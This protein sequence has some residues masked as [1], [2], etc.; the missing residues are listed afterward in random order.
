MEQRMMPLVISSSPTDMAGSERQLLLEQVETVSV[1][2]PYVNSLL[3]EVKVLVSESIAGSSA[4]GY[5]G[6]WK[7]WL[8]FA[9]EHDLVPI[10]AEPD[11][12]AAHFV[13][14][15]SITESLAPALSAR[16]A[17][18]FFH[19]MSRPDEV[20]PRDSVRVSMAMAGL[21][22]RYAKPPKK[23][24]KFTPSSLRKVVDYLMSGE[25]VKLKDH[26][27][28]VFASCLWHTVAR[29]EELAKVE[30]DQVRVLEGGSIEL[31]VASAKNY[32]KDDPRTG[33]ISPTHKE[34]CPVQLV[35]SY[36]DRIRGLFQGGTKYLFPHLSP[37]SLPTAKQ[38]SYQSALK[39][40]REVVRILEIPVE[41][42]KRFRLHSARGGAATAT[43]NAGVPLE[44]IRQAGRL[45]SDWAPLTYIQPSEQAR[46]IVC[47]TL[48]YLLGASRY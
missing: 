18:G 41:D 44:S 40:L 31:F 32:G 48:S 42:G 25:E 38:M 20:V 6:H 43:S 46:G 27:M 12:L 47:S 28:A 17:I 14:L 4:K 35:L 1:N 26:R 23:A 13:H 7:R 16:A 5:A 34:D 3:Q 37:K 39:Q 24:M 30:F 33:I 9:A 11:V 19:K 22:H 2:S 10:P 21:K 36:M 29:Y 8:A 45:S 15:C